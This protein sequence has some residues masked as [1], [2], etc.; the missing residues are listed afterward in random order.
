MAIGERTEDEYN[1]WRYNYPKFEVERSKAAID[2]L[3]AKK[4][5][6]TK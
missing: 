2:E 3:R 1:T 5:T 6:T 4:N